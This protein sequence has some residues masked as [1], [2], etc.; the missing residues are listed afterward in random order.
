MIDKKMF[1]CSYKEY[2]QNYHNELIDF[3]K[4]NPELKEWE[5]IRQEKEKYKRALEHYKNKKPR[6]EDIGANIE[7]GNVT[8]YN[9]IEEI[10]K[11]IEEKWNAYCERGGITFKELKPYIQ[12][13][14][15]AVIDSFDSSKTNDKNTQPQRNPSEI[16]EEVISTEFENYKYP[17]G[18]HTLIE[19]FNRQEDL[20]FM[21]QKLLTEKYDGMP[22]IRLEAEGYKINLTKG[23]YKFLAA[24]KEVASHNG[25]LNKDS[26]KSHAL[27]FCNEFNEKLPPEIKQFR[28]SYVKDGDMHNYQKMVKFLKNS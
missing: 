8:Q 19:V 25:W 4:Q 22:F 5:F 7:L 6:N 11:Y 27:A 12:E 24:L 21:L 13:G 17:N 3:R 23:K 28:D 20:K 10:V 14:F 16:K 15:D 1:Y 9:S 18:S 2:K 26:I